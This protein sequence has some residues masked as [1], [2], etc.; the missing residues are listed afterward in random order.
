[1]NKL[2]KIIRSRDFWIV[3]MVVALGISTGFFKD[4]SRST[5]ATAYLEIDYGSKRRAF[6]GDLPYDMTILDALNASARAGSFE[7]RYV[8]EE[9]RTD[10]IGINGFKEMFENGQ[11]WN[12]YLNSRKVE[13]DQL[14]KVGIK[15]GDKILV[16]LE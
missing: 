2:E 7:V 9:D 6:R 1:M 11:K 8:I 15:A 12:F 10:I 4:L 5:A 13:T 16:K 3:V 14:H